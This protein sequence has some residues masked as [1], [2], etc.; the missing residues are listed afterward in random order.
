MLKELRSWKQEFLRIIYR[1]DPVEFSARVHE[2]STDL[3][4]P[5]AAPLARADRQLK[6][7]TICLTESAKARVT[8]SSSLH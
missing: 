6:N 2:K 3:P 4:D 5:E 8:V 1:P 7:L